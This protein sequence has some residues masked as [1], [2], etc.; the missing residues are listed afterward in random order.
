[1]AQLT[2]ADFP[3]A[4]TAALANENLQKALNRLESGFQ[5]RRA[6]AIAKLPEFEEL[7]H[8]AVA[9]KDH[10]MA[11]LD[12]YLETFE[13]HFEANGGVL[14]WAENGAQAR[15]AIA[16]I[17]REAGA[18]K[19]LK[20]K[21]MV[22]EE[23]N[24]ND[25]LEA[26]G[27]HIV[28]T[29]LGEYIIQLRNETPSHIIAPAIHVHAT[30]V[31]EDFREHHQELPKDRPLDDKRQ[32]LDE[33]RSV[34]REDFLSGHVGITGANFLI[35]ETG[36]A[37][38][39]TNEGNGDLCHTRPEVHIILTTIEKLI[40]NLDDAAVMLRLL[41]RSATGQEIS[42]YTS[43]VTG[44]KREDEADGPRECHLV[45]LDGGRSDLLES[46]VSDVLRCIRCGACMNHCPIYAAVGGHAYGWVYPGPI[47][48]ILNPQLVGLKETSHLPNASSS[49]GRC[50][51]VCPVKIPIPELMRRWREEL[52]QDDTSLMA[53]VIGLWARAATRPTLWRLGQRLS[54]RLRHFLPGILKHLPLTKDW[55]VHRELPK[56]AKKS[57]FEQYKEGDHDALS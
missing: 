18:H 12:H 51:A 11:H 21:S 32:L 50:E 40:P 54:I 3:N 27:F 37:V 45:L 2:S 33:A 38:I 6:E 47:G 53:R 8:R 23:I 49:C 36:S 13:K 56:P 24:L 28:E 22:S 52:A 25:H 46:K 39:V 35:A 57:F 44:P 5:T 14:H 20:G 42:T 48:S 16:T 41:A 30:Q 29:D 15:E 34:L 17:C 7:R 9:I 10:A 26:E 31:A 19:I 4:A 1:M 43:F 55:S